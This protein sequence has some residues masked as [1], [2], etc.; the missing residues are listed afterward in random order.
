[1]TGLA[2]E[3][4]L[5]D[6]LARHPAVEAVQ[7]FLTDPCCVARGKTAAGGSGTVSAPGV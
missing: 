7:V 4:E 2:D 3:L 1:M 6:F 5:Q